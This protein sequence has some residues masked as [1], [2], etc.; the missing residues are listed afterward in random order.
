MTNT[1]NEIW[2]LLDSSSVGGIETHIL[3][4]ADGLN[5]NGVS[6]R[7][8]FLQRYGIHPL[9]E[10]LEK[11]GINYNIVSAGNPASF[12]TKSPFLPL[13]TLMRKMK[14]QLIHTHGYKAGIFGRC[15]A[16]YL[17]IKS[18]STFHA[19]EKPKGKAAFYDWLDRH[20]SVLANH[21]YSV[22]PQVSARLSV[23]SELVENFVDTS[24]LTLSSGN[25]IAFV[26]RLSHEK[27]PDIYLRLADLH[28]GKPFH[29]YG[30]GPLS[31]QLMSTSTA[32]V[33]YHGYQQDMNVVWDDVGLLVITSRYEGLPMAA[34]E[35]MARGIP[36][37]AFNVGALSSLIDN[38]VNGWLVDSGDVNG[39]SS[40]LE[41]WHQS[42][43]NEHSVMCDAAVATVKQRYSSTAIMPKYIKNY[44]QLIPDIIPKLL[45]NLASN[46]GERSSLVTDVNSI[47]SD[48]E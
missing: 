1:Q 9:F 31:K 14:P 12:I 37:L 29:F 38:G 44:S 4:L 15:I 46:L 21:V 23:D 22:S 19:G 17:G 3:Q 32:N 26:G 30:D 47:V 5:K 6:V 24:D 48:K 45:T 2:L 7:V 25:N 36:V 10:L 35:A 34:I 28:P 41:K 33:Y 43:E 13:F 8:V 27:G 40:C 18:I 20:L 16:K 42:T 39:L 11:K